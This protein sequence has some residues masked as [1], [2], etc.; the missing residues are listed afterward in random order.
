VRRAVDDGR[1]PR[2]PRAQGGGHLSAAIV[3]VG[4]LNLDLVVRVP[5]IPRGGETLAGRDMKML[6]GGKGANQAAAAA[7]LGATTA[8]IGRVGADVFA[9]RLVKNLRSMGVD[10]ERIRMDA[11]R[12]TG[13]AVVLVS[14]SGENAIVIEPGANGG[15]EADDVMA[16]EPLIA[17]SKA[18]LLQLEVPL[19]TVAIAADAAARA[20]VPVWLNAAPAP[21][22]LP[23]GLLARLDT[24]VVNEVEAAALAG[25]P[26][27]GAAAAIAAA[28]R[29]RARGPKRVCVTLGER[30]AILVDA[31]GSRVQPAPRVAVVDTTAAGDAFVA[32][33]AVASTEGADAAAALRFAV[34]AGSATVTRAGAQPSLPTRLEVDAL[35]ATL[36]R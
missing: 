4:S 3:V 25:A 17:A 28:S 30:G 33:L 13:T 14:D 22:S 1:R 16:A 15:V 24:L 19:A 12:A 26:V 34:A 5:R 6:P 35:A 27:D 9:A 11:H 23:D 36:S 18:L 29:L 8:M 20:G 7:K 2:L 31:S 21:E 32:A 10:V